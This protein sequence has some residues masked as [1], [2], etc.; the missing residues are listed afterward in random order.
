MEIP[1]EKPSTEEGRDAA[2]SSFSSKISTLSGEE[3][4]QLLQQRALPILSQD[5]TKVSDFWSQKYRKEANKYWDKFYMRNSTNFFKDRHWTTREFEELEKFS[6]DE[7][8]DDSNKKRTLLELGCGVGNFS[9]PLLEEINDLFIYASDFSPRAVNFLQN[10]ELYKKGNCKGFVCDATV[11]AFP[12][13]PHDLLWD[14]VPANS[15]DMVAMIFMLS[16]IAPEKMKNVI[17][18]AWKSLKP[19]GKV[20]F[21][22]YG[23]Y[24][25]AQLRFKPG[26]KVEENLYVRQDGT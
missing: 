11:E 13:E 20:L 8:P 17:R 10:H 12:S 6:V 9:L 5:K 14:A 2:T 26:S 24:D 22:D 25:Q 4:F 7:A 19:G 23:I 3:K 1:I 16:A 15:V 21:R 18:N